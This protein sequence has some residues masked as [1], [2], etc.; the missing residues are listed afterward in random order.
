[1]NWKNIR[2]NENRLRRKSGRARTNTLNSMTP[3]GEA[4]WAARNVD[5]SANQSLIKALAV[6]MTEV[7]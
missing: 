3:Q 5:N 4:L 2:R 7:K 1:M 6:G